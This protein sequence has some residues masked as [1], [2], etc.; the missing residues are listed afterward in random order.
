MM[1][2]K[3][4]VLV[5][6]IFIIL[7][8]ILPSPRP[9]GYARII[10]DRGLA[11]ESSFGRRK[12]PS[13]GASGCT[14]VPALR[15]GDGQCPPIGVDSDDNNK[16][17]GSHSTVSTPELHT[18]VPKYLCCIMHP[19]VEFSSGVYVDT[20]LY[21][22]GI[23]S[24]HPCGVWTQ[25]R[26]ETDKL[27]SDMG[28]NG[29]VPPNYDGPKFPV[30]KALVMELWLRRMDAP[31]KVHLAIGGG[32][33]PVSGL[34]GTFVQSDSPG[35]GTDPLARDSNKGRS[36]SINLVRPPKILASAGA[37][38]LG[39][40]TTRVTKIAQWVEDIPF[41]G[42]NRDRTSDSPLNSGET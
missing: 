29:I 10:R 37:F 34:P 27:A 20:K 12:F 31:Y 30:Q 36:F 26:L 17:V 8:V 21:S 1:A 7:L 18:E 11:L 25:G 6:L 5:P 33:I 40:S 41:K 39:R 13:P 3:R 2:S 4:E 32:H 28:S 23:K 38:D 35:G 22:S 16:N 42:L 24:T 15:P 19:E 14:N 9:L